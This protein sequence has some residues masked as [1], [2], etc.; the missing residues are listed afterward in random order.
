M[1]TRIEQ[2]DELFKIGS[3]IQLSET[4]YI[5]ITFLGYKEFTAIRNSTGWE[6]AYNKAEVIAILNH[7]LT[8]ED[9]LTILPFESRDEWTE[10]DIQKM[11]EFD[12]KFKV[13]DLL[14]DYAH[15]RTLIYRVEYI[16]LNNMLVV[17][18][19]IDGRGWI[20]IFKYYKFPDEDN[21]DAI[22]EP[23]WRIFEKEVFG[24]CF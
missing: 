13:G 6:S 3:K 15:S 8:S 19:M 24:V 14:I 1:K 9:R 18:D 16:G 22:F 12:E 10:S 21:S 4:D 7:N 20:T 11:K 23:D 17:T 5:T 2:F